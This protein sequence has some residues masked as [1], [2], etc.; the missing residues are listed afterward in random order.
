MTQTLSDV[1]KDYK[2]HLDYYHLFGTKLTPCSSL[3]LFLVE[4]QGDIFL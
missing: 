1:G 2:L 3:N 4:E